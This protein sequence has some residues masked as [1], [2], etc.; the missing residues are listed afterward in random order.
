[1]KK[2]I[3]NTISLIFF[4]LLLVLMMIFGLLGICVNCLSTDL[5]HTELGWGCSES[6]CN[7]CGEVQP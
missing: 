2:L 4:P 3:I 7:K 1:M 5:T 6:K